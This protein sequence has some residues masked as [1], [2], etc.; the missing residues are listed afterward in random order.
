[1]R[2]TLAGLAIV[3]PA[4]ALGLFGDATGKKKDDHGGKGEEHDITESLKEDQAHQEDQEDPHAF[5]EDLDHK[6][7]TG[8]EL[9]K[10][11][12][13]H[14]IDPAAPDAAE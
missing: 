8:S 3:G 6:E 12:K 5:A 1:M 4:C 2:K 9:E 7:V 14:H 13:D 10:L 11:E